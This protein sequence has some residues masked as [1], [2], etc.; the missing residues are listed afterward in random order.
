MDIEDWYG[1]G[2][3][4]IEG[5]KGDEYT[6]GRPSNL[7]VWELSETMLSTK[8]NTHVLESGP[9]TYVADMQLSLHV[10]PPTPESEALPKAIVWLW[11]P[12]P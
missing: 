7:D 3:E 5:P 9:G 12:F 8:E 2:E 11:Y 6:T 10:D 1:R 4:R